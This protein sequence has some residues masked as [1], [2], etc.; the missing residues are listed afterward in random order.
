[1]ELILTNLTTEDCSKYLALAEDIIDN[2]CMWKDGPFINRKKIDY[3]CYE[4]E[5]KSSLY[6]LRVK[7]S[8]FYC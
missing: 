8:C 5:D 4:K 7:I 1:M 6:K 3:C 2:D